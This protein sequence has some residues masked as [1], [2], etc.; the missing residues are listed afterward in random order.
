[1]KYIAVLFSL[2]IV[3]VIVLAD[4]GSMPPFIRAVYDFP[5]GDK[6]GHFILFGLLNFFITLTLLRAL[7]NRS[8]KLVALSIGLTLALLI[9]AEEYSQK[10]FSNR[11]FDLVDLTVSYLGVLIGGWVALKLKK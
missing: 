5:N 4:S 6:L 10:Y 2:F 3:G 1:M 9:G 7:P 11:T 8:P